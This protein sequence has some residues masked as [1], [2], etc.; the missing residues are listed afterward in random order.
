VSNGTQR[1]TPD[2]L[3]CNGWLRTTL[4]SRVQPPHQSMPSEVGVLLAV[5]EGTGCSQVS[6][7]VSSFLN[8]LIGISVSQQTHKQHTR[9]LLHKVFLDGS[10]EE[11]D[12]SYI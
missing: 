9:G 3:L 4:L 1:L 2:T 10:N 11:A 5:P 7:K 8:V 12:N 6:L